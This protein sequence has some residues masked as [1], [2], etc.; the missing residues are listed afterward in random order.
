MVAYKSFLPDNSEI[1]IL[2][3][4]FKEKPPHVLNIGKNWQFLCF[5]NVP[6]MSGFSEINKFDSH[7]LFVANYKE[8]NQIRLFM[9]SIDPW[10]QEVYDV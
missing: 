9:I 5:V 1:V 7:L 2:N 3:S 6:M 10:H 4:A 8:L